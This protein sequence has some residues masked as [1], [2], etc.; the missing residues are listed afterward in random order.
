MPDQGHDPQILEESL[1]RATIA[2]RQLSE[3]GGFGATKNGTPTRYNAQICSATKAE[4]TAFSTFAT[5]ARG[6]RSGDP[7]WGNPSVFLGVDLVEFR[8]PASRDEEEA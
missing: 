1:P 6:L 5:E 7:P 2:C 3:N 8:I 4:Y